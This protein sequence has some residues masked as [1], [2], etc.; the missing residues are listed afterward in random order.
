MLFPWASIGCM[1]RRTSSLRGLL[2]ARCSMTYARLRLL[3]ERDLIERDI[4]RVGVEQEMYIVDSEGY[5]A[6]ISDRV[7]ESSCR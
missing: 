2:Y 6:P 4:R 5:P 3:I 7:L 1:T